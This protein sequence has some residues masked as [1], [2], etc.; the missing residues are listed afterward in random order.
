MATRAESTD[1]IRRAMFDDG[2]VVVPNVVDAALRD[3]A[4]RAINPEART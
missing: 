1:A 3:A 4:L 2:V